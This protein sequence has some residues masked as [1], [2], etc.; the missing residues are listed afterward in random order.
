VRIMHIR[1]G[2]LPSGRWR[3]LTEAEIRPLYSAMSRRSRQE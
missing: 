3:D 2:A 1:L